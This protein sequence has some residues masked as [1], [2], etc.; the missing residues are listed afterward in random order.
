MSAKLRKGGSARFVVEN[1]KDEDTVVIPAGFMLTSIITKKK[2]T[3]AGNLKVGTASGGEQVVAT[4][5]L[6]TV[7]GAIASQ[8]LVQKIFAVDT[9]LFIDVSSAATGDIAFHIQKMF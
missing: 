7:D 3:V 8:T 2:G 5:A 4:V 1:F 6:G 9:T